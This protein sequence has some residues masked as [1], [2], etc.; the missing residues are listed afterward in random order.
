MK[1]VGRPKKE[2]KRRHRVGVSLTAEEF[3]TLQ[4]R[5]EKT[6]TTVSDFAYRAVLGKE[7]IVPIMANY[8]AV[9]ELNA[10]GKNINLIAKKSIVD[11]TDLGI[12]EV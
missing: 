7:I 4:K 10:I 6:K 2:D 3:L 5:A 9:R 12:I 1:K 11:K 8:E